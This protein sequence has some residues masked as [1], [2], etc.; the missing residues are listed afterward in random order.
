[1]PKPKKQKRF[2][3]KL[4]LCEAFNY[5]AKLYCE[6]ASLFPLLKCC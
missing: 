5:N 1:M 3:R 6:Q 2:I 4:I